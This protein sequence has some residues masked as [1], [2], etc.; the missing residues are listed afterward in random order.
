[1]SKITIVVAFGEGADS[2]ALVVVELDDQKNL[3]ADG[4]VK[5]QFNPGDRPSF[6]VHYDKSVL[7]L[8]RVLCSSGMVT[9]GNEELRDKDQQ[10]SFAN[11]QGQDLP[12]IPAGPVG[13]EWYGN[14]PPVGLDGRRVTVLDRLSQATIGA[15]IP[16]I[17]NVT[18]KILAD[19]YTLIPPPLTLAEDENWP[20]LV[21]VY[22]EPA[23]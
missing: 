21:V 5:T 8:D 4:N 9:G 17:G 11:D 14:S 13:W 12:H 10:M 20:V 1:M 19:V 3:D 15:A 22:M 2:S 16:A 18:Y 6:I 7:R 23:A